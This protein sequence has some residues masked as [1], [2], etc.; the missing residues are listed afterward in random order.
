MKPKLLFIIAPA[1]LAC[2]FF[3]SF[4]IQ[5]ISADGFGITPPY[6]RN[7]SLAQNSRYEQKII[8]VRGSPDQDLVAKVSI[9][10]PGANNW[11]TIDKGNQFTM[12]AGTQQVPIFVT[13][14]VPGDA[15]LGR[16][17]GSIQIVVSPLTPPTAGTV[18]VTI[19]AQIDVDLQ[20]IDQKTV[21]F[22]VHRVTMTNAEVGHTF[23]WMHFP[24]KINFSMDLSN[25]G[26]VAGSPNKVQFTYEDYLTQ[27]ILDAE[28][29]TNALDSVQPF[30]NKSVN[31]E[32]PVYLPQGTY[33]VYYQIFGRDDGDVVGQ[34]T[35]DLS[36]L[37]QGSLSGYIGYDFWGLRWQEKW[38]T[39]SII[40]GLILALWGLYALGKMAFKRRGRRRR[41]F[42]P[43]PAPPGR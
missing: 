36:V 21:N 11:I 23:W 18:G 26:N 35:L 20:V 24:G 28:A 19:G 39:Y 14:D 6:V 13:V 1:L 15:K 25:T 10:V 7:D 31:A 27:K 9:N 5:K 32:M 37:P 30:D 40:L 4:G 29:N 17:Q 3:S 22:V 2:A 8:L 38:I 43:P 16:Y 34:G 12:P 41:V 42:A 33:K